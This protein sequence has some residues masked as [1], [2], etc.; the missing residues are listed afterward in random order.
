MKKLI[1]QGG[2]K[3]DSEMEKDDSHCAEIR[4]RRLQINV[5]IMLP[6][7]ASRVQSNKEYREIQ[8]NTPEFV[9]KNLFSNIAKA[10]L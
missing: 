5:F 7:I 10:S 4:P 8:R 6:S 9:D 3:C 1:L 2:L